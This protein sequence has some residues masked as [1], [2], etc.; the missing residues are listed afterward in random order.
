MTPCEQ[1]AERMPAVAHGRGE[2]EPAEASHLESCAACQAEWALV[3]TARSL[4]T[5]VA[6]GLDTGRMAEAVRQ[7]LAAAPPYARV[8]ALLRR[9]RWLVGLAA[10]AAL[11]L[12]VRYSR[13]HVDRAAPPTEVAGPA[14]TANV[15]VSSALPELDNLTATELEAVLESLSPPAEALPHVET[16][17]LDDLQPQELERVLRALES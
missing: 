14:A 9:R 11:V 10:A 4:G 13:P 7:R 15:I 16:G 3:R 1:I 17:S 2:W 12:A 6:A 8:L 5:S